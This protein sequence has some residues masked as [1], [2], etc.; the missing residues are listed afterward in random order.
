MLFRIEGFSMPFS[1]HLANAFPNTAMLPHLSVTILMD[2]K[3]VA[4]LKFG[5]S[6]SAEIHTLNPSHIGTF[7]K[8][9][10]FMKVWSESHTVT[11]DNV[12]KDDILAM[13]AL[14]NTVEGS[15]KPGV[16]F[17]GGFRHV[18]PRT[19]VQHCTVTCDGRT[20]EC[21]NECGS[22]HTKSKICC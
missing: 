5:G 7:F 20:Q 13:T 4:E 8:L 11:V 21:C 6:G 10:I 15:D 22:G 3:N 9:G 1:L 14:L 18:T 17:L 19:A 2:G 12:G 16:F